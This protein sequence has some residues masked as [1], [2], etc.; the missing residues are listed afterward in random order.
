MPILPKKKF[1]KDERDKEIQKLVEEIND[2]KTSM[3][4]KKEL[5]K[6]VL[7]KMQMKYPCKDFVRF[8]KYEKDRDDCPLCPKAKECEQ[9]K[10][11]RL[12]QKELDLQQ[13]I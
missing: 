6:E 5:R 1:E 10:I 12:K 11:A 3:K 2:K 8:G 4:R 7:M 13:W 9:E